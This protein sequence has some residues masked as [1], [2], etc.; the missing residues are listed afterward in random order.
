M[1]GTATAP[2]A[3]GSGDASVPARI[4]PEYTDYTAAQVE[5]EAARLRNRLRAL[6]IRF[7]SCDRTLGHVLAASHRAECS[8]A[9]G[10]DVLA[11]IAALELERVEGATR[12]RRKSRGSDGLLGG[13]LGS[14]RGETGKARE[15]IEGDLKVPE[16]I[17]RE[18]VELA[19]TVCNDP[20]IAALPDEA[21]RASLA[22]RSELTLEVADIEGRLRFLR[23]RVNPTTLEHPRASGEFRDRSAVAIEPARAGAASSRD[24]R[25]AS[26]DAARVPAELLDELERRID[27]RFRT[28]GAQLDEIRRAVATREPDAANASDDE[29]RARHAATDARIDQL[30]RDLAHGLMGLEHGQRELARSLEET[31]V[32]IE[33]AQL[34]V[35]EREAEH[36]A[37]RLEVA[38]RELATETMRKQ[39]AEAELEVTRA[40][41]AARI[42]EE[43]LRMR[44][45]AARHTQTMREQEDAHDKALE[46]AGEE[47]RLKQLELTRSREARTNEI[48]RMTRLR[49]RA[50]SAASARRIREAR[51]RRRNTLLWVSVVCGMGSLLIGLLWFSGLLGAAT[52]YLRNARPAVSASAAETTAPPP[53]ADTARGGAARNTSPGRR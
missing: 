4:Y 40:H 50:E 42:E 17:D 37:Q 27:E 49:N 33:A 1:T 10:G 38:A 43:E 32:Q 24:G 23:R 5:T 6:Q 15:A 48:E 22:K 29:A 36:R 39:A 53:S 3:E 12:G 34:R 46:R 51:E 19:R 21:L 14:K 44:V 7:E 41:H 47:A 18:L 9:G 8:E 16:P 31:L 2:P 13:L 28:W 35:L 25:E 20:R 30:A 26:G 52:H 11:R 45:D